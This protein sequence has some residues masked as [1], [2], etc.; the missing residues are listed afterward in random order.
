MD[1]EEGRMEEEILTERVIIYSKRLRFLVSC[2][3]LA[4]GFTFLGVSLSCFFSRFF[5]LCSF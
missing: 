5:S 2:F 3:D 4:E 1:I